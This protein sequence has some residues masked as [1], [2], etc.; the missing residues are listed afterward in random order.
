MKRGCAG[1]LS[2]YKKKKRGEKTEGVGEEK[3]QK[4]NTEWARRIKATPSSIHRVVDQ[5]NSL[6]SSEAQRTV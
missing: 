2:I 1:R 4:E 3:E 6:L 5:E